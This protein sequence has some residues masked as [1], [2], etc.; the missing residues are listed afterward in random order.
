VVLN[1]R[2]RNVN[3]L[4]FLTSKINENKKWYDKSRIKAV[5]FREKESTYLYYADVNFLQKNDNSSK[6][7]IHDYGNV[8]L[9]NW[10]INIDELKEFINALGNGTIRIKNIND[11]K[12]SGAFD[13]DCL[14][15]SSRNRYA[16]VYNEWPFWFGRFSA[17]QNPSVHFSGMHDHLTALGH[18][19]YPDIM[20]ATQA[21][22]N[23]EYSPNV[24][25]P[26]GIMFKV[27]DFRA[28][29]NT[30]EIAENQI[31]VT[32][33]Q[34]E[35]KKE[36]LVVQLFCKKSEK[37]SH[38]S[39]DI[40]LDESGTAQYNLPFKPDFVE[41]YLLE[42]KKGEMIDVKT[43]G[44]WYTN[45]N[46]GIIVR[47]SKEKIEEMIA[48]GESQTVEFKMDFG[49]IDEFLESIVAFANTN[50]GTILIG[51]N[52]DGRV[53][54]FDEDFDKTDKK[55]RNL[56]SGRCE[57]DI[58]LTVE[59]NMIENRS[60]FV[61]SV[62]EGKDKPYLLVGKSAYKRVNKDDYVLA[63]ID[64]DNIYTKKSPPRTPTAF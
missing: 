35:M 23:L 53:V 18:P 37:N 31:K 51:V 62:K 44:K 29:I 1:E 61:V 21:F 63:R 52:N 5:L 30:L 26:I 6:D 58:D 55:I 43:F 15:I 50:D 38:T 13:D 56:V 57:P 22:L 59:Q 14:H 11:I 10:H 4:E 12:L 48:K 47:T 64:F 25:T 2:I 42:K 36:D 16:G 20:E 32:T 40:E 28:R 3:A 24:N 45:R 39:Q 46:D 9:I 17:A 8:V 49:K 41:A 19:A 33:E 60:V 34:R 27:P 54:G 7:E